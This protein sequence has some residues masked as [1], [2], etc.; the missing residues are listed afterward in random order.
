[1]QLRK[2]P[3]MARYFDP[4]Y[5]LWIS[6]DPASQYANPY[7]YGVDPVNY[8][9]PTGMFAI[10]AGIVVSWDE[11]HGWGIGLG[12]ALN[13]TY[14]GQNK[15]GKI[16]SGGGTLDISAMAWQQ[17]GSHTYTVSGSGSWQWWIFNF[18]AGLGYSYNTYSGSTLTTQG[19]ACV[20]NANIACGGIE[21]GGGMSW[22]RYGNFAG[23]TVYGEMVVDAAGGLAS[24]S[25]GY[26]VGLFGAEGRG[27]YAG[28]TAAGVHAE[29]THLE[30]GFDTDNFRYSGQGKAYMALGNNS[31]VSALDGHTESMV[32]SEIWIPTLGR[33]GHFDLGFS[34]YDVSSPGV[35]KVE[36]DELLR[37]ISKEKDSKLWQDVVAAGSVSA[38]GKDLADR[39]DTYLLSEKGGFERNDH[40]GQHE[41]GSDKRTYR[42]RGSHGYGNIEIIVRPNGTAYSSYNY[43]NNIFTHFMID[44]LGYWG[45]WA[46]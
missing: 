42:P 43:G 22:D 38:F 40:I 45:R 31:K 2:L 35:D 21:M 26:E 41:K 3:N 19:G 20:G 28:A 25:T 29:I 8:M 9:D 44:V 7:T 11:D 6:P 33:F 30:D 14:K 27:L 10:G 46:Q 24:V 34:R 17:D 23:A 36:Y 32:T 4:F 39:V 16:F 1:M 13:P 5:G 18:N 12:V 37:L 15:N